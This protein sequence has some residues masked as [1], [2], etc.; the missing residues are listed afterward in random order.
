MAT[1]NPTC[2]RWLDATLPQILPVR[3]RKMFG[4]PAWFEYG[5]MRL[6]LMESG[7][8]IKSDP[9]VIR[10]ARDSGIPLADFVP[11]GREAGRTWAFFALPPAEASWDEEALRF[12]LGLLLSVPAPER[13]AGRKP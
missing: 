13:A 3:K 2:E 9:G 5:R 12:A 8:G 11:L 6:C 4:Y 7:I 10:S 1:W